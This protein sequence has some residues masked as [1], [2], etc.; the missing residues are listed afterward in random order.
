[1][2]TKRGFMSFLSRSLVAIVMAASAT[3]T[4]G[5]DVA[6][7]TTA[8]IAR[9]NE[10]VDPDLPELTPEE[11]DALVA[12]DVLEFRRRA[13][14]TDSAGQTADRIRMIGLV[15]V[16]RPRILTW[17]AAL[18]VGTR[19]AKRLTEHRIDG[20]EIGGSLWYQ[21]IDLPWPV[22]D[23]HWVIRNQKNTRVT[24]AMDGRVWEHGWSLEPD[25]VDIAAALLGRGEIAHLSTATMGRAIYLPINRGAW[26]MFELDDRHTLVAA[27]VSTVL[28]GWIPDGW[29]A[30][31]V[32]RQFNSMLGALTERSDVIADQYNTDVPVY[33]GAGEVITRETARRAAENCCRP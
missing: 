5:I 6:A 12:G 18:D 27:H 20:D 11:L 25:G 23:R 1:M 16:E 33:T 19:H 14:M 28:G 29:V 8:A 22:R 24:E 3:T 4:H 26:T 9:Y 30:S 2:P 31:Y 21:H 32:G 13:P 17:L 10:L 15:I 7:A